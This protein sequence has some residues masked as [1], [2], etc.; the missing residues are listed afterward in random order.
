MTTV[1]ERIETKAVPDG[2]LA[3]VR[4]VIRL[5]DQYRSACTVLEAHEDELRQFRSMQ[6]LVRLSNAEISMNKRRAELDAAIEEL[7]LSAP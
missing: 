4:K 6:C 3:A 2:H 1:L 5:A 7:R